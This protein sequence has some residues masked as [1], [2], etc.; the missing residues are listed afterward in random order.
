M[1]Q[2]VDEDSFG[3]FHIRETAK[4]RKLLSIL[5]LLLLATIGA[6]LIG[7]HG[8]FQIDKQEGNWW[9]AYIQ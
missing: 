4:M 1:L 8:G 2:I 6:K 7:H 9:D 5:L 3:S